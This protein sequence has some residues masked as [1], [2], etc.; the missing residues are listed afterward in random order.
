MNVLIVEPNAFRT[1]DVPKQPEAMV[2]IIG[3]ALDARI[4]EEDGVCATFAIVQTYDREFNPG[5]TTVLRRLGMIDM[6]EKIR[7]I[8]VF[9]G[10]VKGRGLADAPSWLCELV[11]DSV[12][13][14][15]LR[16]CA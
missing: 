11:Q 1:A 13:V 16:R 10:F 4:S 12:T 5:A 15:R 6:S 2:R 9:G 8:V 3:S 14:P 7:G